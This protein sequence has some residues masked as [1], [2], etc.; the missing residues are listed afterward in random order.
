M[1]N[2]S[3]GGKVSEREFG[4]NYFAILAAMKD[5]I[6]VNLA[7][8]AKEMGLSQDQ[9]RQLVATATTS[10]DSVGQGGFKSLSKSFQK[11]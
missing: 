5:S 7:I 6:N 1:H 11:G 4:T 3:F 10:V 2:A 8:V 9:I